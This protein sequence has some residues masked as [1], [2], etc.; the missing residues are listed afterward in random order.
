MTEQMMEE[1]E[2]LSSLKDKG[3]LT[4]EEFDAQKKKLLEG[5]EPKAATTSGNGA[6]SNAGAKIG[7]FASS[8]A[9]KVTASGIKEK[10]GNSKKSPR[11]EFVLKKDGAQDITVK[12]PQ[13]IKL[14]A[15]QTYQGMFSGFPPL[16]IKPID[17]MGVLTIGGSFVAI[18]AVP[19]ILSA[20]GA[21]AFFMLVMVAGLVVLNAIVTKNYFYNFFQSKLADGYTLADESQNQFLQEAGL[22]PAKQK[23]TVAKITKKFWT[24]AAAAFAVVFILAVATGGGGSSGGGGGNAVDNYLSDL[25]KKVVQIEKIVDDYSAGRSSR[26]ETYKKSMQFVRE[27]EELKKKYNFTA[28][29]SD[30]TEK[31]KTRLNEI[32]Q[33][34]MRVNFVLDN[35][36]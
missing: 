35:S 27:M 21:S 7:N 29:M 19:A 3:I 18:V 6:A 8:I 25:E 30:L 10:L 16:S 2:K 32:M 1:L 36:Y 20:M 22:L 34:A 23:A 26:E 31:Q 5:D 28:E 9:G 11:V 4:Q 14:S 24:I 33:R 12:C 17:K 13:K 15:W